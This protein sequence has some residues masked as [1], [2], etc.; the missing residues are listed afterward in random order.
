MTVRYNRL[1][2]Q[3]IVF[4]FSLY[5]FGPLPLSQA[6]EF[7]LPLPGMRINLSPAYQPSL[8]VGMQV[9]PKNPFQ[10]NFI[11][12]P[13]QQALSHSSKQRQYQQMVNYFMASL[14]I[15]N[16]DMWVN[17]SPYEKNR[18]IPHNFGQTLMGRDLLSEDYLLKQ[19]TS[20]LIYPEEGIGKEFWQEVYKQAKNRWGTTNIPVNTFNKVWIVPDKAEVYEKDGAVF[21]VSSHLKVMLEED[22]LS[23]QR[24]AI[25]PHAMSSVG[26][27]IIRQDIIPILTKE[28]NEG[29]NFAMLRQVYSAMLMATWFKKRL[30]QS[31]LGQTYA[32]RSKIKGID[33]KNNQAR[34]RIYLTYLKAFKKGAFN[35]IHEDYD[36]LTHETI[37]RKYFSGG[38]QPFNESMIT[39]ASSQETIDFA[40]GAVA[41]RWDTA[42]VLLQQFVDAQVFATIDERR[43]FAGQS[44]KIFRSPDDFDE[45][46][47]ELGWIPLTSKNLTVQFVPRGQI[48]GDFLNP[49]LEN[50]IYT[51]RLPEDMTVHETITLIERMQR[52]FPLAEQISLPQ[53]IEKFKLLASILTRKKRILKIPQAEEL[54]KALYKLV[55]ILHPESSQELQPEDNEKDLLDWLGIKGS[56]EDTN[57]AAMM[58]VIIQKAVQ[59]SQIKAQATFYWLGE[60]TFKH[61]LETSPAKSEWKFND[62]NI[63]ELRARIDKHPSGSM[64]ASEEQVKIIHEILDRI[65][66][67]PGWNN[68]KRYQGILDESPDMEI[69]TNDTNCMSKC[70]LLAL[71]LKDLGLT[72]VWAGDVL[73][74]REKLLPGEHVVLLARLSD[75]RYFQMDPSGGQE[76]SHIISLSPADLPNHIAGRMLELTKEQDPVFKTLYVGDWRRLLTAMFYSSLGIAYL[77]KG[78]V[79]SAIEFHKKAIT[80]YSNSSIAY[81]DL[82]VALTEKKDYPAA[83]QVFSQAIRVNP[84]NPIAWYNLGIVLEK[85]GRMGQATEAYQKAV[86]INP[87]Y[88]DAR[89]NLALALDNHD[90]EGAISQYKEVLKRNPNYDKAD[91]NLQIIFNKINGGHA[92]AVEFYREQARVYPKKS[93]V[94]NNLGVFLEKMGFNKEAEKEYR[95][96]ISLDTENSIALSNLGILLWGKGERIEAMRVQKEAFNL[97]PGNTTIR[98]AL[99]SFLEATQDYHGLVDLYTKEIELGPEDISSSYNNLGFNLF[100]VNNIP[101]AIRAYREALKSNPNNKIA[102]AN[103]DE[104]VVN[105]AMGTPGGIDFNEDLLDM[106]IKRDGKGFP[107]EIKLQDMG[108]FNF[109]GLS[110]VILRIL[111]FNSNSIH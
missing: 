68:K 27:S 12:D 77:R 20:S 93:N 71:Y 59:G 34:E 107:L 81:D 97:N 60:R 26:A 22:F 19:M 105:Q 70:A 61:D 99:K 42:E 54:V 104:L 46:N 52:T 39:Y 6:D 13:G 65:R 2:A 63:K 41:A 18:I 30:R 3:V 106:R 57:F 5:A 37:A 62:I 88:L 79:E 14:T 98:Q 91:I 1:F 29:K 67:L 48:K 109:A 108:A 35:F 25:V 45:K 89:F 100:R 15:P 31:I 87:D 66:A 33:L 11:F 92:R 85:E 55:S 76:R 7:V 10:L 95:A 47:P 44:P 74:Y 111:P 40:Q 38:M 4:I 32:D 84:N 102:K 16:Q 17:L 94:H 64:D 75:D 80:L 56:L 82:G 24:H 28:I 58:R 53:T 23:L 90:A 86:E 49:L 51:Y 103:L 36:P 83:I 101:E 8:L 96:A 9:N 69:L 78:D 50:A 110:P 73:T 21:I 43:R 72:D